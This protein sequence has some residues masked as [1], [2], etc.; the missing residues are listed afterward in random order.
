MHYIS[1]ISSIKMIVFNIILTLLLLKIR[2]IKL[3][4]LGFVI[5]LTKYLIF[6][7]PSNSQYNWVRDLNWS[8]ICIYLS[9]IE[10]IVTN[11]VSIDILGKYLSNNQLLGIST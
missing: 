6:G 9:I 2:N 7:L 5:L 1:F 10:V 8:N 4:Y 11:I 3:L